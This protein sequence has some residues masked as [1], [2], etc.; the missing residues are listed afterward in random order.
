MPLETIQVE[1]YTPA[2]VGNLLSWLRDFQE[3]YFWCAR[4]QYPLNP[5]D[6]EHW[7][8]DP[9]LQPYL[10]KK[11]NQA[12][13]YGE[14]QLNPERAEA[15]ILRLVVA[16][17][18]RKQGLGQAMLQALLTQVDPQLIH[19]VYARLFPR[20]QAALACFEAQGFVR[21]PPEQE[22]EFNLWESIDFI[23]LQT[24][25]KT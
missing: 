10:G 18:W 14:I 17:S 12:V 16:P 1:P 21:V 8:L 3:N 24:S 25:L 22:A 15:E 11:A 5:E 19:R 7:H 9:D 20:N 4:K 6:L 13:A 2:E 23:W